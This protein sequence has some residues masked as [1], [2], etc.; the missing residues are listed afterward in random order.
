MKSIY[1]VH[2]NK[3][4]VR[5]DILNVGEMMTFSIVTEQVRSIIDE[6]AVEVDC[7]LHF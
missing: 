5:S 1:I 2:L 7:A 4:Y 6:T 3:E